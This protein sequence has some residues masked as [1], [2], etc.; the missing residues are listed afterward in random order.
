MSDEDLAL[1]EGTIGDVIAAGPGFVAVGGGFD[2]SSQTPLAAIWTSGDGEDWQRAPLEGE[3][4]LGRVA[5]ITTGGPGLVAVGS[6]CCPDRAAVWVSADGTGWSRVA[7]QDAFAGAAMTAVTS[8]AG[9]L[10]AVG[11]DAE[12]E[13]SGPAIWLS[14]DGQAWERVEIGN[15]LGTAYLGDVTA[16]GSVLVAVGAPDPAGPAPGAIL[17]SLDGQ[18]WTA[19]D[20]PRGAISLA[21]VAAG[22]TG[23]VATGTAFDEAAGREAMLIFTST[24]GAEWLS[25]ESEAFARGSGDDILQ[26]PFGFVAVGQVV[27]SGAGVA[28]SWWSLDGRSWERSVPG[29]QGLMSAVTADASGRLVAVGSASTSS[30]TQPSVWLS[31]GE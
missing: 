28:A 8:W 14:G 18:V 12:L 11:C 4:A 9:G 21:G 5:A 3:A 27:R 16:S 20:V 13:C 29:P 1:P 2:A 30:V 26:G 19:A 17:V 24:D 22:R 10:V 23:V 6:H 31:G 15:E 25:V 7:D